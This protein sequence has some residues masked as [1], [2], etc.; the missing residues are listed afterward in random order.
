MGVKV[1]STA[2]SDMEYIFT[3]TN[4][5][6]VDYNDSNAAWG[7]NQASKASM[8]DVKRS[9]VVDREP[10]CIMCMHAKCAV[11]SCHSVKYV[12]RY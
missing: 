3:H 6:S 2:G 5:I 9:R 1:H 8:H 12:F 10:L 7:P 4:A 11:G